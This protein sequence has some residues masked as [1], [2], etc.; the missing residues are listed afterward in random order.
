MLPLLCAPLLFLA[1]IDDADIICYPLQVSR[2]L[3]PSALQREQHA[4]NR[5]LCK[6]AH[7]A[8]PLVPTYVVQQRT[9]GMVLTE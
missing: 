6:V 2:Q 4:C 1:L 8:S 7:Y 3:D 5:L 9:S